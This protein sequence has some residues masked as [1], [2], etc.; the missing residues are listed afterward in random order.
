MSDHE[1]VGEIIVKLRAMC[2]EHAHFGPAVNLLGA[3]TIEIGCGC[4]TAQRLEAALHRERRA[5][6]SAVREVVEEMEGIVAD[7]GWLSLPFG[8]VEKWAKRLREAF[9]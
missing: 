2:D 6:P 9:E 8:A 5:M 1:S 3:A 4:H 7:E